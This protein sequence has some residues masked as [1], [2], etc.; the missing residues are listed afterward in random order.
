MIETI[1]H[2][3]VTAYRLSWWRSRLRGFSVTVYRVRD[4]IID[5]GYP[6]GRPSLASALERAPVRG[7]LLTHHHEDHA[8]NVHWLADNGV[9]VG[10]SNDTAVI[11]SKLPRIGLYRRFTWGAMPA[12]SSDAPPF[13]DASLSLIATPGHCP[14]HHVVFD[15]ETGTL[16][17]GDLFLGVRIKIAHWYESPSQ[18][19]RSLR[20]C[21]AM[22]P[23][24]VFCAHRGLL[25][26]GVAMLT[27]KADWME[28]MIGRVLRLSEQG[29]DATSIREQVFGPLDSTHWISF[30]DYSADHIVR[31]ILRDS[32]IE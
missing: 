9:P 6:G 31:A 1:Q 24:R 7:A 17:S 3:D 14:D 21:I 23:S 29:L 13:H 28:D 19:V 20:A 30:G 11:L 12:F 25:P 5:T 2:N 22:Q 8:G 32:L 10:M 18:Q 16:F 27:A 26:S 4:V 15:R